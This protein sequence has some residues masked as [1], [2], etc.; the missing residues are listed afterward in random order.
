MDNRQNRERR[1]WDRFAIYYDSFINKVFRKTYKAILENI[2][3]DLDLNY[4][5]LEIGT[6]TGIIPFSIYSKVAS[7]IATDISPEM[8]RVAN[9]RIIK[10]EICQ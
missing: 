3:S 9:K 10:S 5:V 7:I 6:G 4:N 2:E 1:F 8:V